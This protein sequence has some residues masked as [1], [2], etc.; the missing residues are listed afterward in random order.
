MA[1]AGSPLPTQATVNPDTDQ[2]FDDRSTYWKHVITF[3]AMTIN[4]VFAHM[5]RQRQ[6][7]TRTA[8]SLAGTEHLDRFWEAH[9]LFQVPG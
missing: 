9:C 7:G 1:L 8:S 6:L 3:I 4:K 5:D 2:S